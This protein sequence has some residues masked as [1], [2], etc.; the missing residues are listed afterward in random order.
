MQL[1]KGELCKILKTYALWSYPLTILSERK[2]YKLGIFIAF[3]SLSLSLCIHLHNFS[4]YLLFWL[5]I[6]EYTHR[7]AYHQ[8]KFKIVKNNIWDAAKLAIFDLRFHIQDFMCVF[9]FFSFFVFVI[10]ANFYGCDAGIA[11]CRLSS[12]GSIFKIN[13][14]HTF[15]WPRS[16]LFDSLVFN[17]LNDVEWREKRDPNVCLLPK[18]LYYH[19]CL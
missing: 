5:K 17:V 9:F 7:D 12:C 15:F 13:Y 10:K 8:H 6:I 1:T 4:Y 19:I 14:T 18:C 16:H 3:I 11:D 2:E